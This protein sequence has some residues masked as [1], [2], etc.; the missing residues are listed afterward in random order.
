MN[1]TVNREEEKISQIKANVNHSLM[2]DFGR[3]YVILLIGYQFLS[4]AT[5]QVLNK[6]LKCYLSL[7][8]ICIR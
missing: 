4:T 3:K 7:Q 2:H 1:T 5:K 8:G 6:H